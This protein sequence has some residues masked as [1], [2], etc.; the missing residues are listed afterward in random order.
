[1]SS[2]P[3]PLSPVMSTVDGWRATL[4]GERE[5]LRACFGLRPTIPVGARSAT[6][7]SCSCATSRRSPSRSIALRTTSSTWSARNGLAMKS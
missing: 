5:R 2:L 4:L 3:V 7:S 6:S 1:M